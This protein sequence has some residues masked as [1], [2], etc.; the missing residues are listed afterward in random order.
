LLFAF[1]SPSLVLGAFARNTRRGN[2]SRNSQTSP[3]PSRTFRS[4]SRRPP[5]GRPRE[6]AVTMPRKKKKVKTEGDGRILDREA[7]LAL[8]DPHHYD[9]TAFDV[10]SMQ[11]P[12][13][14]VEDSKG[15]IV[16]LLPMEQ[17]F[18]CPFCYYRDCT[19]NEESDDLK[20]KAT[21]SYKYSTLSQNAH[22]EAFPVDVSD[23]EEP[24]CKP[25]CLRDRCEWLEGMYLE[26]KAG[27]VSLPFFKRTQKALATMCI[28]YAF[29]GF[30][31][32]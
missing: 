5:S 16:P 4:I 9:P 31:P 18:I 2:I 17:H 27:L 28:G 21:N 20:Y 14:M 6:T 26:G 23:R 12:L 15:K 1:S 30:R 8:M 7:F 22:H 10:F 24:L 19:E 13:Y 25:G 3:E 11:K 29:L 32:K